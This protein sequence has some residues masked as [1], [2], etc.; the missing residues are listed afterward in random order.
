VRPSGGWPKF[1]PKTSWS[2]PKRASAIE[3]IANSLR[4]TSV[5]IFHGA[6]DP[7]VS[8]RVLASECFGRAAQTRRQGSKLTIYP[9][10]QHQ[11][12]GTRAYGEEK[13]GEWIAF[14]EASRARSTERLG[15]QG[16][17]FAFELSARVLKPRAA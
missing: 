1:D 3:S 12:S 14:A 8:A 6:D 2:D 15:A 17:T 11:T 13:L 5:R 4:E 7:G 9:G 16:A 10:M